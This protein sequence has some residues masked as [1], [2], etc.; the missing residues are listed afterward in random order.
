MIKEERIINIDTLDF[1]TEL[2]DAIITKFYYENNKVVL[3][4]IE[5]QNIEAKSSFIIELATSENYFE[6]INIYKYRFYSKGKIKGSVEDVSFIEDKNFFLEIIE[7]G[8]YH[9]TL[10]IKGSIL[11][12]KLEYEKDNILIEFVNT[13]DILLKK[14]DNK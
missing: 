9:A 8:Y 5:G 12:N 11:N 10:F 3:E 14:L 4:M 6:E 2:H 13:K 1:L 7:I